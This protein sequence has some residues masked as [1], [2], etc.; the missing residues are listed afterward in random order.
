MNRDYLVNEVYLVYP[1][2]RVNVEHKDPSVQK[3]PLENKVNEVFKASWVRPD[4]L[5][6]QLN[7]V[8]LDHLV[9]LVRPVLLV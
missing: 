2:K 1:E 3:V 7:V 4:L 8:T 6:N 5:V 9:Q